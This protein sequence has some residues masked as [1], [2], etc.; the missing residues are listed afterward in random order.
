MREAGVAV[1]QDD[2][3]AFAPADVVQP[4]P[5]DTNKFSRAGNGHLTLH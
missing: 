2:R 1:K 4:Q 5:L 3:H